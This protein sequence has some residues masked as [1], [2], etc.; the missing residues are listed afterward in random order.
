M[1]GTVSAARLRELVWALMVVPAVES[2][3]EA[4]VL[5]VPSDI[6]TQFSQGVPAKVA[7]SGGT[8]WAS[9]AQTVLS[10]AL[11]D[12]RGRQGGGEI[13]WPDS[14]RRGENYADN[15]SRRSRRPS[16]RNVQP[17]DSC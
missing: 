2:L 11:L 17:L 7:A 14:Y 6:P 3:A 13:T 12:E 8:F 5:E 15:L 1:A 16:K 4:E 10:W 9:D